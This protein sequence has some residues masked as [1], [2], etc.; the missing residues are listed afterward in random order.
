MFESQTRTRVSDIVAAPGLK[1][2]RERTGKGD[3]VKKPRIG[4]YG[5]VPK[6]LCENEVITSILGYDP[7]DGQ[8]VD[9]DGIIAPYSGRAHKFGIHY[10]I[11]DLFTPTSIEEVVDVVK[12]AIT[13]IK[14]FNY[15]F[16]G[17]SGYVRGDYQGRSVYDEGSKTV[18]GLDFDETGKTELKKMH[19]AILQAIQKC[20]TGIEPEFDKE[21]F[22]NEPALWDLIREYGA[23]YVLENYSPHLTLASGL[24]GSDETVSRLIDYLNAEYGSKLLDREIPFTSVYVFQEIVEGKFEGYF[25]VCEE[26][27]ID[28][29]D[30]Q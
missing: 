11:Y 6:G 25:R 1:R 4:I 5:S 10:T 21:I 22:R 24:D 20:R 7:F 30:Q 16:P 3:K 26:I 19:K 14:A 2:E 15:A 8:E 13:G 28:D 9:Q 23:P 17:F 18:I 27:R 29:R 12:Q